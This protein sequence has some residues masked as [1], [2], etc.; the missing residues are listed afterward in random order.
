MSRKSSRR[1]LPTPS[2][3]LHLSK[4]G[5]HALDSEAVRQRALRKSIKRNNK[6]SKTKTLEVM[7]HLVLIANLQNKTSNSHVKSRIRK[8]IK[9]LQQIY[10][11]N[12]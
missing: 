1:L 3:K 6:I 8:D 10:K 2:G 9:Y 12:D 5:Y 11:K 7:R 4:Y